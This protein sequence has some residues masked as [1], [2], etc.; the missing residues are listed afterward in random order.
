MRVLKFGGSSVASATRMSGVMDIVNSE[1][2]IDR[3][4]LVSSA[5]SGCTDALIE[6]GKTADP[7]EKAGRIDAL[8][9]R[10]HEIVRRLF[11]GAECAAAQE[12]MN[13]I[14]DE[15]AKAAPEACV[16][17]GEIFSTRILARKYSCDGIPVVWLDSRKLV[18]TAADGSLLKELTYGNI[19]EAVGEQPEAR[20]FIAPGF[21][22]SDIEGRPTTLGRG[23]SDYSAAIYAAALAAD[24]L[25]IW[26]DVPGIMTTNPKVVPAAKT[27]SEISYSA[28]FDL[29]E[30]GAKVL[31]APTVMPAREEGIAIN[32]RNSFDPKNPGTVV[33]TRN[34]SA[35]TW[36]GVTSRTVGESE[37]VICLVGENII[38][39]KA[40]IGRILSALAEAGIKP[41]SP[42]SEAS[43]VSGEQGCFFVK[44]RPLVENAAVAALHKEF[45]EAASL[46][47][48]DVFLA[49]FG[50]VGTAL[51]V[52]LAQSAGR[53]AER[54]G[55]TIRIIGAANS[56]RHVLD[57]RGI[58]PLEVV[59]RLKGG[60]SN[61]REDFITAVCETAP[62][63][64]VFIDCT[65]DN[66][67]HERYEELFRAGMSIVTSNRRSLALPYASYAAIKSAARENGAFFRYDTTVGTALP[68]LEA[69]ASTANSSDEI[70][71]IEAVISCTLNYIITNYDGTL[72]EPFATLL[73]R[74]QDEGLTEADPRI[75]LGGSDVLRKLLILAREAGVKLEAEDVEITPMLGP[76]FFDCPLEE[77]YARLSEYE[78]KFIARE[79]ELDALGRRQRFVASLRKDPAA[80]LGYKAEIRMLE[81]GPENPFYWI[82]G[83]ENIIV[84]KS[85]YS[86]PLVIKG[87]GE[88]VRL[89][90]TGIIKDILMQ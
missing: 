84:V 61:A 8:R 34:S 11:T 58:V 24:S 29:A 36:Y 87:A 83:T 50:A 22:S 54:S 69:I 44:V 27:I 74:A 13:A 62:R 4:V 71:A 72:G 31:Y 25:E 82:S 77:F 5:I 30:N 55:K 90:A 14:A 10:H 2:A 52:Q 33:C 79:A 28:A 81:V 45:F 57:M 19:R 35:E 7:A 6:I 64:T 59:S 66:N 38:S 9:L 47:T 48:I 60:V 32:I 70:V 43:A 26:T 3:V 88:G 56:R 68:V 76:E 46:T 41:I 89:A 85:E 51:V 18:K 49:G 39:R 73:Q 20:I 78:P 63:R 1:L 17:F 23:G 40:S 75:D 16:T 86:A 37:S 65:N 12:E 42:D 80:R 21:I 15:L 67:L 53:I